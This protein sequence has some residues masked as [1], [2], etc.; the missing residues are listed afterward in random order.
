M[1]LLQNREKR[2]IWRRLADRIFQKRFLRKDKIGK[3]FVNISAKDCILN[4]FPYNM[5]M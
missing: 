4:I 5:V 1:P 3:H 2:G